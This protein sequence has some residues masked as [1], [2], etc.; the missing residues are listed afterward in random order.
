MILIVYK[1]SI[2]HTCSIALTM[3]IVVGSK[4]SK[5]TVYAWWHIRFYYVTQITCETLVESMLHAHIR[6]SRLVTTLFDYTNY[7]G[8][9]TLGNG[10]EIWIVYRSMVYVIITIWSHDNQFSSDK[11]IWLTWLFIGHITSFGL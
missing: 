7:N 4:K 6:C 10:P 9:W 5:H 3:T 2:L 8:T 11:K 1:L